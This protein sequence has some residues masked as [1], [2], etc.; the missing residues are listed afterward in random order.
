MHS[1]ASQL[2]QSGKTHI[3]LIDEVDLSNVTS[4]GKSVKGTNLELD[5]SYISEYENVH[6]IFCFRPAKVGLNNF[7][8]SFPTLQSNQHF[9]CLGTSYRNTKAI[10]RLIKY[11]LSRIGGIDAESE[12]YSLMGD[13]P[14]SKQLPPPLI[15][16]GCIGS[17]I[18]I[19]YTRIVQDEAIEHLSNLLLFENFDVLQGEKNP[20]VAILLTY[21]SRLK[22]FA[23]KL[24]QRNPNWSGP[25]EETNYNGSEADIIV[26]LCDGSMNI[27]TLTRARRLLIILTR[28]Q[29]STL[30][31]KQAVSKNLA[32]MIKSG[33]NEFRP[34]DDFVQND[35]GTQGD[36][37]TE[38]NRGYIV[39]NAQGPP[40]FSSPKRK[41][42]ERKEA[43]SSP[44]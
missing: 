8:I 44:I 12:G 34:I 4:Q 42:K 24:I 23:K 28:L 6:F 16:S 29:A 27:Q 13:I 5:L 43:V 38:T 19:Q 41:K 35:H 3:I 11:F 31:L 37:D 14:C 30:L 21:K 9:A 40:A 2:N 36:L 17:V 32:E 33:P 26:Y 22:L 20:S 7:S 15:P 1:L 25:H 39:R 18:W 10:Q